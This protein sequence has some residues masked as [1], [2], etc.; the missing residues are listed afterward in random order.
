[1]RMV[2][3]PDIQARLAALGFSPVGSTP[4]EFGRRMQGDIEKWN[5]LV[6]D[7]GIKIE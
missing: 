5:K 1:V 7:A 4:D 6:R 2:A 3:L